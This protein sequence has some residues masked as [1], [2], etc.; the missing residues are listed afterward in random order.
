MCMTTTKRQVGDTHPKPCTKCAGP[1]VWK[2]RPDGRWYGQ[3]APCNR[4]RANK[5]Y[6]ENRDEVL[7]RL[8]VKNQE[9]RTR[10][11]AKRD[12][13]AARKEGD[14]A[15]PCPKC[16]EVR[17]WKRSTNQWHQTCL[18]CGRKQSKVRHRA[19]MGGVLPSERKAARK[20]G[21]PAPACPKCAG[22]RTWK[23]YGKDKKGYDHWQANCGPCHSEYQ[24][25]KGYAHIRRA[26][27]L[28]NGYDGLQVS[29]SP[30]AK[31]YICLSAPVEHIDHVIPLAK[32]GSD[33]LSNK[34]GACAS[35]NQAKNAHVWPGSPGWDEFLEKRRGA[36]T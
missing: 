8:A 10:A 13:R 5:H 31:C 36:R 15:T 32:G 25:E 19:R 11:Q 4:S 29:L 26:R 20:E 33:R 14:P 12:A 2:Q 23:Q 35:C 3:C 30:N 22:P 34:A 9:Q 7:A 16:S 28:G 1:K 21:D 6:A 27:K 17:I 18:P 24:R